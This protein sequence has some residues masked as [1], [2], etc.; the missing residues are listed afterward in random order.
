MT[1]GGW[2]FLVLGWGA[3]ILLVG[4]CARRLW[5]APKRR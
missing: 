5:R 2:A 1:V 3:V 4:F